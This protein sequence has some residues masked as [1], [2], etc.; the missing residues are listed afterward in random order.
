M[1]KPPVIEDRQ[2]EHLL[3]ATASYSR[4]PDRDIA[5]LL[6]L[7]GTALAVAELATITVGDY[8]GEDGSVRVAS[9]VRPAVAHNGDDRP[10]F[11]SNKRIVAAI[12]AYLTWRL[13]HGQGR[14]I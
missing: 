8:V 1:T 9:A 14:T 4:T 12:D 3:K 13:A 5:L 10:L 7:Y 11:W 6:T 2:I